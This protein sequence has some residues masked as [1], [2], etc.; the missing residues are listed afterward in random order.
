[1][2]RPLPLFIGLRYL[3]AKRRNHFISFISLTSIMGLTLGVAVLILVLSVMNGFDRE[4]QNRILGMVSQGNVWKPGGLDDWQAAVKVADDTL[5]VEGAAPFLQL[6]GM[7]AE[8]GMVTGVFV[9]GIVPDYEFRVSILHKHMLGGQI[10][11][12]QAG[13]YNMVI[14]AGIARKLGLAI[15]DKVTLVMPEATVSPAGVLP[16]FKRFTV[17]GIFKV[18]AEL[19]D[20]MGYVALKDAQTV[21][22]MGE[23]AQGL[24]LRVDNLFAAQRIADSVA[25]ALGGSHYATDWTRTHGNLFQA[26]K[27][28]KTMMALLL[29]LIVAV[30]AFNIVSSLVMVVTDK[31]ADIAILRTLGASPAAIMGIFVVQGTFIGLLGVAA[32]TLLGIFAALNITDFASWLEQVLHRQLFQQYFVNYLPSELRM[33]H[34]V[35]VVSVAFLLSFLATLYPAFKASRVQPAEALRHE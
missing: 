31:K 28:E 1:M 20:M 18:G 25:D 34:V 26:I 7:L 27:L 23:K 29:M 32:G 16:R 12:L 35:T 3:R 22:R 9:N 15:G 21:A 8:H 11:T 4:L 13:T 10:E 30:A 24:R 14:G 5:G 17:S 19:D 6:Q 33:E 2:F